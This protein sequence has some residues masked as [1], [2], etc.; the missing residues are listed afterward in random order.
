MI[1]VANWL[2][3]CMRDMDTVARFGGDE[4]VVMR[5]CMSGDKA[6]SGSQ[7]QVVA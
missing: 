4:F 1:E 2:K 6:E 3:S 7:V 5:R